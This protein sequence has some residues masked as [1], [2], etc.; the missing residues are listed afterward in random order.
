MTDAYTRSY[1]DS[2]QTS[3][4]KMGDHPLEGSIINTSGDRSPYTHAVGRYSGGDAIATGGTAIRGVGGDA[5]G[6]HSGPVFAP[7]TTISFPN[8]PE[9]SQTGRALRIMPSVASKTGN[10]AFWDNRAF[11]GG[12]VIA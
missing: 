12:Q 5:T 10:G 8:S 4:V 11:D 2:T 3:F 6:E 7:Q 1:G 9:A